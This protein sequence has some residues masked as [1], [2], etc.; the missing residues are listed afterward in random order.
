MVAGAKPHSILQWA[1]KSRTGP[2][3]AEADC[4]RA[5]VGESV[6]VA[7]ADRKP[8]TRGWLLAVTWVIG[9]GLPRDLVKDG[10]GDRGSEAQVVGLAECPEAEVVAAARVVLVDEWAGDVRGV[11][12]RPHA[13]GSVVCADR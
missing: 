9:G 11:R 6:E 7:A 1:R 8:K 5:R 4:L 13:L 2:S 3:N 10:A 12:W